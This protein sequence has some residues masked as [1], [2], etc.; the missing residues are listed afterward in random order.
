MAETA[1]RLLPLE[2]PSGS[3][4]G[5]AITPPKH[6]VTV[7]GLVIDKVQNEL[8]IGQISHGD[9]LLEIGGIPLDGMK[10][11][12]AVD[13]LKTMPRP[14]QLTFEI[15][16]MSLKRM[17]TTTEVDS[18]DVNVPS[19]N[20]VFDNAKMGLNLD[21][22]M[23]FGID[24]AI[25]KGVRD[26][27]EDAGISVG[28]ILYKVNGTEVLFMSLKQANLDEVQRISLNM[29]VAEKND[30]VA[31]AKPTKDPPEQLIAPEK[32]ITEIIQENRSTV[33]KEGPMYKQGQMVKNWKKRHFVLAVSKLEYFKDSKDKISQGVVYFENCRCTVRSLPSTAAKLTGAPGDYV[34][35]LMAGDRQFIMSCTSEDERM[36]WL[37]ALKVAIDASKAL[38]G[39]S[40]EVDALRRTSFLLSSRRLGQGMSSISEDAPMPRSTTRHMSISTGLNAS[41]QTTPEKSLDTLVGIGATVD[42]EVL[43]I[44]NLTKAFFH[45]MNPFCEVTFGSETFK[46]PTVKD[47]LNPRWTQDN[48]VTFSVSSV[49]TL[50]E[51]RVFDE[52]MIRA[53]E[54][55]STFTIPLQSLPRKTRLEQTYSLILA[56]RTAYASITLGLRYNN[57]DLDQEVTP[58]SQCK[59]AVTKFTATDLRHFFEAVASGDEARA[60]E[61]L[62]QGINPNVANDAGETPLHVA[63]RCDH[64][65]LLELLLQA[66][67][68]DA[69]VCNKHG[70]TPLIAA[71]KQGHRRF[72]ARIYTHLD[73]KQPMS[74]VED[75]DVIVER[76]ILGHGTFGVVFKG[77]F[78]NQPVAVKT[79]LGAFASNTFTYE[80]EAMELCKS[81][82]LLRLLAVTGQNTSSPQLVLE[83]MDGGDLRGYLDKKR[84]DLPVAVEY[85]ALEV[86]W[87]IANALADLHLNNLLH[88][89]LKSHN[90]LLS[91]THYIKVADLGTVRACATVMTQGKGTPFWTAPEVL[92]DEGNYDYAAD[93]YSFGVILTELSTL[94][95]PYAGLQ[96][97]QSIILE[98][99]RKGT[100]RPD[101]G[102]SS[103][104]WLRDLATD[105]MKYDPNE[106]PNVQAILQRLTD[107]RRLE[108]SF[109]S[110]SIECLKCK[111]SHPIVAAACPEC[112]EPTLPP[113]TKLTNL[114]ERVAVAKK[115]GIAVNASLTCAVCDMANSVSATACAE[116]ESELPDD[117]E[118]LQRLVKSVNWAMK[119]A[120]AA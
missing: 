15:V 47:S 92:A 13:L 12:Y 63:V 26:F 62:A 112:G 2:L 57:G 102:V 28:D 61:W 119:V 113:T 42:I 8:F 91:S 27:A 55:L 50:I 3:K 10:F 107:R 29:S 68:V 48:K 40:S 72:A 117:V 114:L 56:D 88:R 71:I 104:T 14:L 103:P 4:L 111:A 89:D 17:A 97:S 5:I 51:V 87:V 99:V 66:T 83:Y 16:P 34:L 46:T 96:L 105:C 115:R 18:L 98:R 84:D 85:S 77:I 45:V 64:R 30:R 95:L 109:V 23:R 11:A 82:Y 1:P 81:P 39:T 70:D 22:G 100:L 108:A 90:V 20:V 52:R 73:S 31:R 7:R 106:R 6:G 60:N 93:V 36:E 79:F 120:V 49:D 116:C 67:G 94:Q 80:M 69:T 54:L 9:L 74:K 37:E 110:T 118:K 76:T 58:T 25:V 21:D 19:Y 38:S 24:G 78:D 35:E 53:P 32:S 59:T 86:A 65:K 43:S 75:T 41:M 101:V 44:Q 33:I